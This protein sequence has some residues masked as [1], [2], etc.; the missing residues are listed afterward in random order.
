MEILLNADWTKL[1]SCNAIDIGLQWKI[2]QTTILYACRT[3][4][5]NK[6]DFDSKKDKPPWF[7]AA[8][9][10]PVRDNDT[11]NAQNI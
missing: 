1:Y 3:L 6:N 5:P 11:F 9:I 10:D 8:L 2:L 7:T 4:A